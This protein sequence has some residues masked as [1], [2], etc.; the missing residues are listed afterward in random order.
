MGNFQ[1]DLAFSRKGVHYV[2]RL[3][4]SYP[5]TTNV[6][7]VQD[8]PKWRTRGVDLLWSVGAEVRLIEVKY[9]RRF[10]GNLFLETISNCTTGARGWLKTST[11]TWIAFGFADASRWFFAQLDSLRQ[12]ALSESTLERKRSRTTTTGGGVLYETEGVLLPI[13][14]AQALLRCSLDSALR[15]PTLDSPRAGTVVHL[16]R[17]EWGLGE[18][19][20]LSPRDILCRFEAF[21]QVRLRIDLVLTRGWLLSANTMRPLTPD[22]L[23]D[24]VG[25][26]GSR[27]HY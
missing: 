2:V 17:P 15:T 22:D 24:H 5:A 27:V 18:I 12:H 1:D 25:V 13:A 23:L 4:S 16:R 20:H 10:T 19:V 11:A 14:S 6:L 26:G 8:D 3:L 9:E 7:D 21:G